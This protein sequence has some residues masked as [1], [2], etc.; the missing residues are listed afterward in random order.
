MV[1]EDAG[2]GE[3]V[4]G[5]EQVADVVGLVEAELHEEGPAGGEVLSRAGD[6]GADDVQ[7]GLAGVEGDVGLAVDGRADLV[8]VGDVRGVGGDD[9]EG[10]EVAAVVGQRQPIGDAAASY[11]PSGLSSPSSLAATL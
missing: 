10:S 7:S 1:A 6:E 9:V 3:V 11:T 5:G 2:F 8:A 4:G